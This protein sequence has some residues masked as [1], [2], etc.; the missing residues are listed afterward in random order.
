MAL[1]LQKPLAMSASPRFAAC[2]TS[3]ALA[4]VL[5]FICCDGSVSKAVLPDLKQP[6]SGPASTPNVSGLVDA[7]VDG[8]T[9]NALDAGLED[10]G[11]I[12]VADAS[13]NFDAG[14]ALDAGFEPIPSR[15]IWFVTSEGR[16]AQWANGKTS[17]PTPGPELDALMPFQKSLTFVQGLT[18]PTPA[19]VRN[20]TISHECPACVLATDV[21]PVKDSLPPRFFPETSIDVKIAQFQKKPLLAVNVSPE[22]QSA[23]PFIARTYENSVPRVPL[24]YPDEIH[25]QLFAQAPAD[26]AV[27]PKAAPPFLIPAFFKDN[28]RAL[29]AGLYCNITGSVTLNSSGAMIPYWLGQGLTTTVFELSHD[30]SSG[31]ADATRYVRVQRWYA[32]QIASLATM[33]QN[34]PTPDGKTMLEH[35]LIVWLVDSG[36]DL[37]PA[38][39]VQDMRTVVVGS[40][41]KFRAGQ[42]LTVGQNQANL[43]RTVAEAIDVPV[44]ALGA[45][46]A[47]TTPIAELLR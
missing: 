3:H 31:N 27:P 32:E 15:V 6:D 24:T 35:T 26:C 41:P 13:V 25:S 42:H 10:A 20:F 36:G 21:I 38:H 28:H 46:F 23:L 17:P 2:R 47:G 4:A 44:S 7:S 9:V 18:L 39:A 33:L 11:A 1:G 16:T 12:A 8:G 19:N 30:L 5:S 45:D 40:T 22:K 14:T 34:M 37:P 43:L 29:T